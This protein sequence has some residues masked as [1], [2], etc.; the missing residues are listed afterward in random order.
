MPSGPTLVKSPG[1]AAK[2]AFSSRMPVGSPFAS[3]RISPPGG[4]S[5]A[6]V[7]PSLSSAREFAAPM[8]PDWWIRKTGIS[9]ET[10]S[11]SAFVG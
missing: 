1:S 2:N 7:I 6:A 3:F 11:S 9:V 4:F 5:E 8:C 10:A